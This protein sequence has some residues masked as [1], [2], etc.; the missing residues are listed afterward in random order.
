MRSCLAGRRSPGQRSQRPLLCLED[1]WL[2]SGSGP[3][4]RLTRHSPLKLDRIR[5]SENKNCL[6]VHEKFG[7]AVRYRSPRHEAPV[8]AEPR[9]SCRCVR[10]FFVLCCRFVF[11][12]TVRAAGKL[13]PRVKWTT[14]GEARRG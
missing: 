1:P 10:T 13:M 8:P 3:V 14:R 6:N 5:L 9:H 12:V 7:Q 4:T 11:S 2:F